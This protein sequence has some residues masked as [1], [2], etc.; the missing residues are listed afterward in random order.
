VEQVSYPT[1]ARSQQQAAY[2]PE[3]TGD[4]QDTP[5]GHAVPSIDEDEIPA[6]K[7]MGKPLIHGGFV[8]A[9]TEQFVARCRPA[10]SVYQAQG[11]QPDG[12]AMETVK[13]GDCVRQ[14]GVECERRPAAPTATARRARSPPPAA[15][16]A[17]SLAMPAA[18]SAWL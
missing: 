13:I 5:A 16:P 10:L 12:R 18:R 11:P 2:D 6:S 1:G 8:A 15:R 4:L 9:H 14:A 7:I 17:R 3:A